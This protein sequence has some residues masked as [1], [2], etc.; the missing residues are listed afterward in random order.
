[1]GF[2]F[3]IDFGR[4]PV[5][6]SFTGRRSICTG[7]GANLPS[8]TATGRPYPARPAGCPRSRPTQTGTVPDERLKV[9]VKLTVE[10][11]NLAVSL[12]L[13][14]LVALTNSTSVEPLI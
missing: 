14:A 3:I 12:P 10:L 9:H 5:A 11:P 1:M 2:L 8:T 7:P 6:R 4:Y 13:R